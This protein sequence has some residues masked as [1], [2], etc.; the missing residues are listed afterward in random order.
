MSVVTK[1]RLSGSNWGSVEHD[2][3]DMII[4]QKGIRVLIACGSG[5]QAT[6]EVFRLLQG[7]TTLADEKQVSS[8]TRK[9]Y[10]YGTFVS[11]SNGSYIEARSS[12]SDYINYDDF[13]HFF[14]IY[15]ENS[16]RWS[17]T[18]RKCLELEKHVFVPDEDTEFF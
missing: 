2:L 4:N 7:V 10:N 11:F 18:N 16:K 15:N 3:T 12:R 9:S 13:D 6:S 8:T 5:Y 17:L 14:N 1:V